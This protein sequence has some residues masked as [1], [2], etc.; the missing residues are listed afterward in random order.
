[1]GAPDLRARAGI[2][3]GQ[4]ALL[5]NREEGVVVGDRVNTA[6]RIQAAADPGTVLV[7]DVTRQVTAAADR[8][9]RTPAATSSRASPSRSSCGERSRRSRSP[10]ASTAMA[11]RRSSS[12]AMQSCA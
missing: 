6:A 4:A 8:R 3:T 2:V 12:G 7:D 9:T 10:R 1:M 11:C 5:V